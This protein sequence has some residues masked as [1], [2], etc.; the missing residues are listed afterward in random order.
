V[1]NAGQLSAAERALVAGQDIGDV[2]LAGLLEDV[3]R[4][5]ASLGVAGP[6]F[7]GQAHDLLSA[8]YLF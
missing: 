4:D 7:L 2:V 6:G 3:M 5:G 1:E 8:P